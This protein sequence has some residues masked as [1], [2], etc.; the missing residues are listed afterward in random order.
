MEPARSNHPPT[1][2]SWL[3]A[4]SLADQRLIERAAVEMQVDPERV[5][6]ELLHNGDMYEA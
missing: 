5:A 1:D 3:A 2:R 4:F 6:A